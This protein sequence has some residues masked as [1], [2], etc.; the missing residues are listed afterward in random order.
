MSLLSSIRIL[1]SFS[2][3]SAKNK[4]NIDFK[5]NDFILYRGTAAVIDAVKHGLT[6]IYVSL[7]DEVTVDPFFEINKY[8]NTNYNGKLINFIT[9]YSKKKYFKS[10]LNKIK[11]FSNLFYEK[12]KF[13]QLLKTLHNNK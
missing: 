3:L 6:P 4:L 1:S 2:S 8:H 10:E 12:P 13:D 11:K 5:K 9:E 7:K